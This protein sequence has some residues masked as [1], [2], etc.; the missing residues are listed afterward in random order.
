MAFAQDEEDVEFQAPDLKVPL[1]SFPLEKG[2]ASQ[3]WPEHLNRQDPF[4]RFRKG[5][6]RYY[7]PTKFD[8]FKEWREPAPELRVEGHRME[9]PAP[10]APLAA[11]A[12]ALP[13]PSERCQRCGSLFPS[14]ANF[15]ARCGLAR[16]T[17]GQSYQHPEK[18]L[19]GPPLR[20]EHRTSPGFSTSQLPPEPDLGGPGAAPGVQ[21]Q[22][23]AKQMMSWLGGAPAP[24][25][26][27]TPG[28]FT[29]PEPPGQLSGAPKGSIKSNC[30]SMKNQRHCPPSTLGPLG[31]VC[32]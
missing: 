30:R 8:P 23:M 16:S 29:S 25:S 28:G 1:P 11:E 19:P 31:P 9:A 6:S 15:C 12:P 24:P 32:G 17:E 18:L 4:A 3:P 21:P 5:A 20:H 2:G 10:F 14:D 7:P 13:R 22:T 26:T 27:L